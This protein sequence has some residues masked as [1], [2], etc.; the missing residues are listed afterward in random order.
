MVIN[1]GDRLP[2]ATPRGFC[3][4][5]A[6][7][8][9]TCG[10]VGVTAA[11]TSHGTHE[12]G[13]AEIE[14]AV[15]GSNVVVNFVSPMYNLVGFERAPRDEQDREAVAAATVLLDDPGN[16]VLLQADAQCTVVELDIDWDAPSAEEEEHDDEAAEH[17]AHEDRH[18][19]EHHA[20]DADGD[21]AHE[22]DGDHDHD[23]HDADEQHVDVTLDIRYTCDHPDRL[24]SLDVMAFESFERLSEVEFRAVGPGGAV[25]ESPERD[26]PRVD[27]RGLFGG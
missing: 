14:L 13:T 25:A 6:A 1:N 27:L 4:T 24:N 18:A 8:V 16:L 10:T 23:D 12:H 21:H 5:A 20:H 9:L 26:S 19:E 11:E 17:D 3:A 15:E 22:T 7:L 2:D